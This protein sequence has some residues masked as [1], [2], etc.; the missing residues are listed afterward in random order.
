[1]G[2]WSIPYIRDQE[3]D[4]KTREAIE[5]FESKYS[6][7]LHLP[8]LP[9]EI[10]D[11]VF[12]VPV[13]S[14][15]YWDRAIW[16]W[17][18]A[19]QKTIF[20]NELHADVFKKVVGTRESTIAHE[21]GHHVL[22]HNILLQLQMEFGQKYGFRKLANE[23]RGEIQANRFALRLLLP[24]YLVVPELNRLVLSQ[25]LTLLRQDLDRLRWRKFRVSKK[26]LALRLPDLA[27]DGHI[28]RDATKQLLAALNSSADTERRHTAVSRHELQQMSLFAER[29][30]R[31]HHYH[32]R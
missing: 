26:A 7:H 3:L 2:R 13:D 11:G 24:A 10:A 31:R 8:I 30:Y 12:D 23:P 17:Y 4:K 22:H 21:L 29:D 1:M 25:S 28:G 15:V 5:A 18:D 14:R 16:G 20:L 27:R 9:D 6:Q 19:K 32:R